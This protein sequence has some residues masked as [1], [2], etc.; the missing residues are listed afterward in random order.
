MKSDDIAAE[1]KLIE[2]FFDLPGRTVHIGSGVTEG[3]GFF[4]GRAAFDAWMDA[5]SVVVPQA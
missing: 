5:P 3:S 2:E 1:R 4:L